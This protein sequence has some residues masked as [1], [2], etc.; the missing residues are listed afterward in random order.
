MNETLPFTPIE[1]ELAVFCER[2]QKPFTPRA[3]NGGSTQRFC[4]RECRTA[5]HNAQRIS[6]TPQRINDE[7]P[8]CISEAPHVG[9]P[10]TIAIEAPAPQD[11]PDD[12]EFKWRDDLIVIPSQ[13]AIAVYSNPNGDLVIRQERP[14]PEDDH[15]VYIA[16][17]NLMLVIDRMCDLAGIGSAGR[18]D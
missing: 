3:S 2:C 4:S 11:E 1:A 7:A 12:D 8:Q 15:F 6:E 18:S 16:P 9:N 17:S 10:E 13:L 5:F 14:Y